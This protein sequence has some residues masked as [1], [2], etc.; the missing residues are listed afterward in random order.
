[1][2][3]PA[4]AADESVNEL[5]DSGPVKIADAAL[6]GSDDTAEVVGAAS[7]DEEDVG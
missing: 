3:V 4:A 6:E 2:A 7:N 5:E 1:M